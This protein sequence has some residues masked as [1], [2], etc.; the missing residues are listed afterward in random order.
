MLIVQSS[1]EQSKL[2]GKKREALKNYLISDVFDLFVS[3]QMIGLSL[4]SKL[5][6]EHLELLDVLPGRLCYQPSSSFNLLECFVSSN[7]V[8]IVLSISVVFIL[9]MLIAG[10][11]PL[12]LIFPFFLLSSSGLCLLPVKFCILS[13][14]R[15]F[16]CF[17]IFLVVSIDRVFV[18]RT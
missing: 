17:L 10:L 8:C 13:N 12:Y 3:N 14:I 7:L 4:S 15:Q 18:S 11:P 6:F 16:N 9:F 5:V 2:L 1:L